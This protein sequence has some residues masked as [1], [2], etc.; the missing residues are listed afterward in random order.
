MK[1]GSALHG[2]EKAVARDAAKAKSGLGR[3]AAYAKKEAGDVRAAALTSIEKAIGLGKA[4]DVFKP[5]PVLAKAKVNAS[6][7]APVILHFQ[8]RAPGADFSRAGRESTAVSI[9]VDGKYHSTQTILSE[10]GAADGFGAYQ[11]NLGA[12]GK[13]AHQIEVRSANWLSGSHAQQAVVKTARAGELSGLQ[14]EVARYAPLVVTRGFRVY[15]EGPLADS[16]PSMTHTDAPLLMRAEVMGDPAGYHLVTYRVT[17]SD[18]DSG[19]PDPKRLEVY[20]RTTDDEWCYRVLLDGNGEKV[21]PEKLAELQAGKS[22]DAAWT[23]FS[24][25]MGKLAHQKPA[26]A[27][28]ELQS[29]IVQYGNDKLFVGATRHQKRAFD[30]ARVGDRP[31]IRVNSGNNNF[32]AVKDG[33]PIETPIWSPVVELAAGKVERAAT[34][35]L[36]RTGHLTDKDVLKLYPWIANVTRKEIAREG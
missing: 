24:N 33:D 1:I 15:A 4:K 14:G 7:G 35:E 19:T 6:G 22:A 26:D 11:V 3:A 13:G 21:P 27:V 30:G 31:V 12:L 34:G 9:F 28:R 20:G 8:A 36:L 23:T 16:R 2:L 17:L 18:E 25:A 29:E 5:G 32:A 10:R